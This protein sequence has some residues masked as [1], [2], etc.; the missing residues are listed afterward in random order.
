VL[1]RESGL[2]S[3]PSR[4]LL[5]GW[6]LLWFGVIPA[7]LAF[8]AVR[9]LPQARAGSSGLERALRQIASDYPFY[10]PLGLFVIL[11]ATFRYW[12]FH[13]PGGRYAF[14]LPERLAARAPLANIAELCEAFALARR[15]ERQT[16]S[17]NDDSAVE[18]RRRI[19]LGRDALE[20]GIE[21]LDLSLVRSATL[22]L[23]SLVGAELRGQRRREFVGFLG[24]LGIAALA[25]ITL[26]GSVFQV[27]RL[28]SGSML[29][30]LTPGEYVLASRLAYAPPWQSSVSLPVRTDLVVFQREGHEAAG[31]LVKRVIGLPGDRIEMVHGGHPVIN[32]WPVPS[33]DAGQ[34][35]QFTPEGVLD[36]RLVVEFLGPV[37]YLTVHT[38]WGQPMEPYVVKPGE[39]F[40]I[41]DDRNESRDSRSWAEGKPA[42]LS[43]AE[44]RGKVVRSIALSLPDRAPRYRW[45][46][47][48]AHLT[49]DL[50]GIDTR[51]LESRIQQ[52]LASRPKQTEPPRAQ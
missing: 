2:V 25:A 15:L 14:G 12:R 50:P 7:L 45:D 37:A 33:C 52:C 5:G 40:V 31:D 29:P 3:V 38:P 17:M 27:Y 26:R 51:E 41:G 13:L 4:A 47:G 11:S 39:V 18:Q 34:Y 24:L 43:L 42:G 1:P 44:V 30:T 49:A 23:K 36:G 9:W 8:V 16:R 20:R 19:E 32:G 10:V 21:A 28:T 22:D 35:V 6:H 48:G 46:A